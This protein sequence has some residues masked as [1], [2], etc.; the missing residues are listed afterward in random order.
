[1]ELDTILR[2]MVDS[3]HLRRFKREDRRLGFE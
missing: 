1:M 3:T 2:E